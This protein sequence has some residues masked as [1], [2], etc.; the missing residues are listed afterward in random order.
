MRTPSSRVK[1]GKEVVE[2]AL[3]NWN[4][5]NPIVVATPDSKKFLP[6]ICIPSIATNL[7][8]RM[9]KK[10]KT[11]IAIFLFALVAN[12]VLWFF[13]HMYRITMA[14]EILFPFLTFIVIDYSFV[15]KKMNDTVDRALFVN[16][17]Y[18]YTS[19]LARPAMALM[20][21]VGCAQIFL[22][23]MLGGLEP[24][25]IKYGTLF[26]SVE[27]GEWWRFIIGPYFHIGFFHWMNNFFLLSV[28]MAIA[29]VMA[30]RILLLYF[31]IINAL[32]AFSVWWFSGGLQ[33]DSVA[34]ISG[35]IFGLF[36]WIVA[37][38]MR[39][40][41]FFPSYFWLTILL[42]T[43]LTI[44]ISSMFPHVS[45]IAHLSGFLVGVVFG[46]LG[47]GI[48]REIS[49]CGIDSGGSRPNT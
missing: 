35:G 37:V 6:P 34:G 10:Y 5:V 14:T 15:L 44:F 17:I 40:R 9:L 48:S 42:F 45:N 47:A 16:W 46:I 2:R 23:F 4:P 22:Q 8:L 41:D 13:N 32:S 31:V 20:I 12:V 1:T 11:A 19:K 24:V 39:Y 33:I 43:S 21:I 30:R 36:G 18:Q 38:S 27:T 49:E 28:A 3:R 26:S 7:H 29:G 25:I